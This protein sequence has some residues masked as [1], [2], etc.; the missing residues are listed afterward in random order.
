D[1]VA[2]LRSYEEI[3][4]HERCEYA[5]QEARLYSYKVDRRTG[6]VLPDIVDRHNHI[7]DAVRY[8]LAPLIKA[9]EKQVRFR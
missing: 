5:Q 1:G 2:H 6:D 4:I 9:P 3:V 7:W 8:A